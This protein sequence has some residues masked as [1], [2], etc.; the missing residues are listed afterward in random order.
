[1]ILDIVGGV[2]SWATD[3]CSLLLLLPADIGRCKS[4]TTNDW[5]GCCSRFGSKSLRRWT[6]TNSTRHTHDTKLLLQHNNQCHF[7]LFSRLWRVG[8]I[9]G[10]ISSSRKMRFHSQPP[11]S[12]CS[13]KGPKMVKGK[14]RK[15]EWVN[16]Y[17]FLTAHQHK[18]GH[19]VP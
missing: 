13:G 6:P 17:S 14:E 7:T 4:S 16:E 3:I 2:I 18:L 9:K 15:R 10:L 8:K 5:R 11:T 12:S 19:P 1:M